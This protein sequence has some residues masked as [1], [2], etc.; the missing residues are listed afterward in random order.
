MCFVRLVTKVKFVIPIKDT[1]IKQKQA[2][3]PKKKPTTTTTKP[4]K[5]PLYR[6]HPS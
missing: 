1:F 4:T 2:P 5:S 3:P 6:I